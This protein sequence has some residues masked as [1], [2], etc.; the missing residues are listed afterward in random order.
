[1]TN[2]VYC[3]QNE[4]VAFCII[5]FYWC[6][7]SVHIYLDLKIDHEL[8]LVFV[9]QKVKMT[10]G[11]YCLQNNFVAFYIIVLLVSVFSSYI[12]GSP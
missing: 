2:G 8:L 4:F 6:P 10:N 12:F 7:F 5:V 1:M 3:L 11:V 9:W